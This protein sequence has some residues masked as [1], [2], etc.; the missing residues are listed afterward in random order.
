M[1]LKPIKDSKNK[2]CPCLASNLSQSKHAWLETHIGVA[3]QDRLDRLREKGRSVG[4]YNT[5]F[6]MGIVKGAM[7]TAMVKIKLHTL[8]Y[9]YEYK[10]NHQLE[11]NIYSIQYT[12]V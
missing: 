8:H 5:K 3:R 11:L 7:W 4:L 10:F 2:A 12:H 1:A 9:E 6:L